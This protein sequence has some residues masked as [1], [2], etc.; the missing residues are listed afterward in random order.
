MYQTVSFYD[1]QRAFSEHERSDSFS[2][3][4]L[5]AL[6][7][8]FEEMEE[9][10]GEQ[11]ELD[12]ISICCDFSEYDSALEAVQ[13]YQGELEDKESEEEA[14]DWLNEHTFVLEC[15]NGHVVIQ[16]F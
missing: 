1:F 6:F 16:D 10:T 5:E 3:S 12:V 14:L 15:D 9:D 8:H 4:G 11:I 2:Y 7:N 13:E